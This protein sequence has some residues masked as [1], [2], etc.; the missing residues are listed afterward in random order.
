[1]LTRNL[2]TVRLFDLQRDLGFDI[3]IDLGLELDPRCRGGDA[4]TWAARVSTILRSV[5]AHNKTRM[6][7]SLGDLFSACNKDGFESDIAG[8]A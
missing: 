2:G 3:D 5:H 8:E 4:P 6:G 7:V 1:M